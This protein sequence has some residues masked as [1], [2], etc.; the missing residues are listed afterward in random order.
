MQGH[1]LTLHFC[2]AS[3]KGKNR[4]AR[5]IIIIEPRIIDFVKLIGSHCLTSCLFAGF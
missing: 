4:N 2:C 1:H 3:C 5:A